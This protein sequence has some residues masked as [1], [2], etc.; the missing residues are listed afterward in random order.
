MAAGNYVH[1]NCVLQEKWILYQRSILLTSGL[2]R[3]EVKASLTAKI[4]AISQ[5]NGAKIAC[6]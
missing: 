2:A 6:G 4:L 5:K 3:I 1:I